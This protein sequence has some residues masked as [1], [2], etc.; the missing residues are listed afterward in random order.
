M[1]HDDVPRCEV[2]VVG[3]SAVELGRIARRVHVEIGHPFELALRHVGEVEDLKSSAV[4]GLVDEAL[5]GVH[6]VVDGRGRPHVR[7]DEGHVV[8]VLHIE[9]VG[10]GVDRALIEF[11][12][13]QQVF[14][15]LGQPTLVGVGGRGVPCG[16]EQ[17]GVAGIGHVHDGDGVFVEAEGDL[18]AGILRVGTDVVH[19]LGVVAVSVFRETADE[20][21]VQRI[22]DVD[23][24]EAA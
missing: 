10:A 14:V 16:A 13:D 17:D 21:G 15:V 1:A 22:A 8:E 24:V 18:L 2:G 19:D 5:V 20:G 11:V 7:S 3:P 6:V 23:D 12:T 4:V 9:D